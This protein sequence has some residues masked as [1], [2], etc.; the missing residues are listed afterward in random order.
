MRIDK[1]FTLKI[2]C[3]YF[4]NFLNNE[5]LEFELIE[6]FVYL[7]FCLSLHNFG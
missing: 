6:N 2:F 1:K 7:Y 4:K 5:D 3:A